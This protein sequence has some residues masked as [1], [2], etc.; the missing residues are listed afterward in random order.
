MPKI[1]FVAQHRLGRSPG[2]RFRHEQYVDYLAAHGFECHFAPMLPTPE[3]DRV[4]YSP[5]RYWGKANILLRS[6]ALRWRN[7]RQADQYDV[8]FIYREALTVGG[9]WF[10]RLFRR[11]RAK[12]ILDFD[13]SIWIPTV[14]EANKALGWLKNADKT[15]AIIALAHLTIVGNEYLAQYARQFSPRVVVVPT[16]IDT[17]LYQPRPQPVGRGSHFGDGYQP[18]VEIGWSGSVTTVEHF[19]HL[20]PALEVIKQKYGARVRFKLIGDGQYRHPSLGIQGQP[21]RPAT[22]VID[23]ATLHI[24]VMPLPNDDWTRGKCGLKG[25]QYMALGI[26][27]VMSPVGVNVDI[28]RDGENGFLADTTAE[29]VDKLSQLIESPGLRARLGQA[30]RQT[31]LDG[32]SFH[33]QKERYLQLFRSLLA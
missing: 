25:L 13:D 9:P 7:Y 5:G 11:S 14:S 16:T 28:I 18:V 22:E 31:V 1:L 23:L 29:W 8:I 33:A 30:G 6:L 32:Y 2:Q 19:K 17:D 12:L 15:K 21:W 26:P 10:E 3:M 27:T 4:F 24:G 20:L